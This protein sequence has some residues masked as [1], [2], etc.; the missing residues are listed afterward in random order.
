[1]SAFVTSA[2]EGRA[3][4][5]TPEELETMFEDALLIGDAQ[6]LAHL[7]DEEAALVVDAGLPL[8]N[9]EQIAR[10]ALTTWQGGRTYVADPRSVVQVGD[11]A[12]IL[13]EGGINVMRRSREGA[14]RYAIVLL[15]VHDE[16]I[17]G[18]NDP[19]Y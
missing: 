1:M 12:L 14:W 19:E 16:T 15:S 2:R 5:G 13:V 8:R 7:F 11:I 4:A 10:L 3:S 18:T 17:G 9:R 6:V